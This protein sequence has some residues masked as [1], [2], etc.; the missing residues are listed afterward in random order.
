V[1]KHLK[2]PIRSTI[3]SV[4]WHPNNVLLA[5]GGADSKV[6]HSANVD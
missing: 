1:S 4:D 6:P 3:L 2:K 5:A